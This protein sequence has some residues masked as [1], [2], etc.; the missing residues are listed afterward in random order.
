MT[1][2]RLQFFFI[3]FL[4]TSFVKAEGISFKILNNV[5]KEV[6]AGT[7]VNLMAQFSNQEAREQLVEVR[8]KAD[9]AGWKLLTDY[10]SLILPAGKNIRKIVGIFVPYSQTAGSVAVVL[11]VVEKTSGRVISTESYE[12][13]V[14]P[15]YVVAM[16]VVSAPTQLFAGD[17]SSIVFL[18]RNESNLDVETKFSLRV[19]GEVMSEIIPIRKDGSH[20]YRYPIKVEKKLAANEQRSIMA[21]VSIDGMDGTYKSTH[22]QMDVF[23][24]GQEK[25]DAYNRYNINITGIGAVTTAYGNPIYSGMFDVNGSGFLG[26]PESNRQLDFKIRGPNRNGNPL[27]GM[28]DEYFARY[29]SKLLEVSLG[30]YNYGMSNLTESSRSGRGVGLLVNLNQFSIGGYYSIPRYYPL[31]RQIYS[32]YAMYKW[33][34]KNEVKAGIL[35]KLDTL[36]HLVSM[37]S[38]SARNR[39][40]PWLNTNFEISLGETGSKLQ[41]AYRVGVSVSSKRV[42]SSVDYTY[43]DTDFPG[44]FKNT[45]RLFSYLTF[46]FS[47]LTLSL[48]FNTSRTNQALDTLA[49]KPPITQGA[50]VTTNVRFLKYFSLNLG[51]MMSSSKEDSPVPLFD[52]QRY[53]GRLGLN[54]NFNKFGLTLHGDGGKLRNYLVD[55][56]TTM[57]NFFTVNLSSY[58]SIK[59]YFMASGNVSYQAGQKGIT[60]SETM[61][62]GISLATDFSEKYSFSLSYN[63]NFEW[64][65]YSSDRNLLS[66][67]LNAAI[68]DNNKVAFTSNY[69]LMKNTLDNKTFNAQL[70]FTHTLRVPISKKKDVGALIGKLVNMGVES[71]AGVRVSLGGRIAITDKD[72]NF[73]LGGI[74]VGEQTLIVDG[75]SFGLHTIPE[76]AGPYVVEIIPAK[77]IN[78]ELSVTKSARIEGVFQVEEDQR[79][80][81]KGFIQVNE[82]LERLV[83]EASSDKETYRVLSDVDGGF[84][85]ED[86]RPGIWNVKVYPNGL[87]KGYNLLT[88]QFSITLAPE[89]NEKIVVKVEKKARQIQFQRKF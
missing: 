40:F 43:A 82:R 70:R 65:Y 28:N 18:L 72:G 63:S 34:E 44:Y 7:S 26:N 27:F 35:S 75:T 50:G 42:G 39:F 2:V 51:G 38:V 22:L 79:A 41:K 10:S 21:N 33:N 56:G 74:P 64:M 89:Q 24:V 61:Y 13:A 16:D 29:A 88:P 55:N 45:Q 4:T 9:E 46:N 19:G 52:Y 77:T 78:F 25:F 86:L 84:Q 67:S 59:N 11:E 49:S 47:P 31:I 57:T 5:V 54:A 58:V 6:Q 48:N 87:P 12:F 85:F 23:R 1:R 32:G 15:R 80:N 71:V 53:N 8:I 68:N 69:N 3:L 76:R 14:Q 36:N 60:G 83:V 30:D 17:T 81:Q 20:L 37:V 66:L 62:Y 73:K